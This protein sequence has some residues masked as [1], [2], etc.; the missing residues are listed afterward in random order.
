MTD[1]LPA[2]TALGLDGEFQQ[3]N[4]ALGMSLARFWIAHRSSGTASVVE[5]KLRVES[6]LTNSFPTPVERTALLQTRWR[7]RAQIVPISPD[8]SM[9]IDGAH[10][11]ESCALAL[12]WFHQASAL[13]PGRKRVLFCNFKPNKQLEEMIA[14]LSQG[15]WD[16]VVFVPSSARIRQDE[17]WQR[18]LQQLWQNAVP[19][20]SPRLATAGD[21][22]EAMGQ[23][24]GPANVFVTGSLYL[25]GAALEYL[26]WDVDDL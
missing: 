13:H 16:R 21:F 2:S 14:V 3:H 25:A 22:G 10:N 6:L 9:F 8:V 15:N 11:G 5:Q 17:T 26:R 20:H 19:E 1:P 4:A 23:V 7:G 18:H 12:R 24:Q